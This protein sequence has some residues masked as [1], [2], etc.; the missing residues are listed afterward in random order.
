M[1]TAPHNHTAPSIDAARLVSSQVAEDR[2]AILRELHRVYPEGMTDQEIQG[3]TG[4][5]E[6]SER[7]RRGSLQLDGLIERLGERRATDSGVKA[8][9]WHLSAK[10]R[11][12]MSEVP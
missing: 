4:I 12:A 8:W 7:P 1:H 10:G 6:N 5:K 2:R 9:V 3:A 11:A